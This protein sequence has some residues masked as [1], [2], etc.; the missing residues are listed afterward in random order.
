MLEKLV[1]EELKHGIAVE[2]QAMQS[3]A[4]RKRAS[5]IEN[6]AAFS[7]DEPQPSHLNFRGLSEYGQTSV[8]LYC[9][10]FSGFTVP[11]KIEKAPESEFHVTTNCSTPGR[12]RYRVHGPTRQERSLFIRYLVA[13][14]HRRGLHTRRPPP[15][16]PF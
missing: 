15:H 16:S 6:S 10:L 12:I 9:Q 5:C 11:S 7:F 1:Q 2:D 4:V 8:S 14:R 3:A 13:G